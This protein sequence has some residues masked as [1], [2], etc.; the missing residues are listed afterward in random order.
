MFKDL[1][2]IAAMQMYLGTDHFRQQ[3]KANAEVPE[4]ELSLACSGEGKEADVAEVE[5]EEEE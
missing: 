4:A 1:E 2:E 5:E 3:G